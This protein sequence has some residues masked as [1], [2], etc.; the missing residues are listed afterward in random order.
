MGCMEKWTQN[1]FG[2]MPTT[3]F[4]LSPYVW[5]KNELLNTNY[6]DDLDVIYQGRSNGNI[7]QFC[8]YLGYYWTNLNKMSTTMI[9]SWPAT[10]HSIFW[11]LKCGSR[12]SFTTIFHLCYYMTG[13]YQIF[14]KIMAMSSTT[15]RYI[16]WPWK[17]RSRSPFTK[18][19]ISRLLFCQF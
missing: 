4:T 13:C 7:S 12:S 3:F 1:I 19:I 14:I 5:E 10:K 16:S 8:L 15:K 17:C 6:W 18:I 9:A 11:R 2:T